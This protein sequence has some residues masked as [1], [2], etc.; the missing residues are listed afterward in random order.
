MWALEDLYP[1][2]S[3]L[4]RPSLVKGASDPDVLIVLDTNVLLLPFK[5]GGREFSEIKA[6]FT[7]LAEEGRLRVPNRVIRE[8]LKNRDTHL[9]SILKSVQDKASAVLN[10]GGNLPHF[11]KDLDVTNPVLE[12]DDHLKKAGRDYVKALQPLID[13][14]KAWRGDDPVTLAYQKIFGREVVVEYEP[15]RAQ[16]AQDWKARLDKKVPPGYKDA[17]KPDK[18]IGDFLIWLTILEIGNSNQKDVIF[19]TGEEKADWLVRSGNEG[20]YPRPELIDEFRRITNGKSLQLLKLA[21]LLREVGVSEGV[22]ED[23]RDAEALDFGNLSY[24]SADDDFTFFDYSTNNGEIRISSKNSST[25]DL[26]FSKADDTSI[27]VYATGGAKVARCKNIAENEAIAFEQFDSTSRVYTVHTG[28]VF[29]VRNSDGSTF[30][31]RIK[32]ISDDSR[33]APRDYVAFTHR[34]FTQGQRVVSP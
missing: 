4:L 12:A 30:A 1:S 34:T 9:G 2:V 15:N 13:R 32:S 16:V 23:V 24:V 3:D 6:V 25:F 14:M 10:V 28:E 31:A 8:Y 33:G 11:F 20:V 27:H 22:V 29:L 7:K 19:V 26:K 17:G 21:D 5:V 18:G